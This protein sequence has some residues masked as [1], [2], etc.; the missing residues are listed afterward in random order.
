MK[1]LVRVFIG[2]LFGV[3]G[4]VSYCATTVEN[5]IT[6]EKQRVQLT[7]REEVALG[8][9]T[10]E[11]VAREF[12]G[13][14]PDP[15]IQEYVDRVGQ[16][17]VQQSI[18]SESQY[19]FDFHVLN[20]RETVNALALPG[21]QIFITM[22]LLQRL[23]SEAQLA[24]VLAHETG[25]AIARHAAE[26]LAKQQLGSTLVTAVGIAATDEQG[27][28]R[29]AAAIAQVANEMIALN[30]GR[31][32]ELESDRL[33]LQFMTE[34]GYDPRAMI[35]VMQILQA[36]TS[37]GTP[38]EFLSTHPQ[39]E[40]RIE[41]LQEAIAEQFPNGIPPELQS[42]ETN[43]ARVMNPRLPVR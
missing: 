35:E 30:Y 20:D 32:D 11:E 29:E 40:S 28:G 33:G 3:V 1:G 42:G 17:I 5:P 36:A 23:N 14:Y 9:Q 43:F 38:P 8:L 6:G 26:H 27:R 34:A 41:R 15:T 25:H 24:G 16:R 7:P 12:G 22:G 10:R 39:P 37:G 13:L 18:A 31:E 2:L 21:G 4:L 19:P